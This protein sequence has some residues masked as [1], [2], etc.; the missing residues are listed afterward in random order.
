MVR[1]FLAAVALAAMATTTMPTSAQ[2]AW[3]EAQSDHFVIY[4][5]TSESNLRRFSEQLERYHSAMALVTGVQVSLPSP[6][7]RV[8]VFI[9]GNEDAVRKLY[10]GGSKFVSGFYKARAGGSLA[11]V[12]SVESAQSG[13]DPNFSM[14]VLLHEYA[15]HFLIS[16]SGVAAPRWSSEGAAEFFASAAFGGDGSV[17]LGRAAQHRGYELM[18]ARDVTV[19]DLLDPDHYEKRR[20]KSKE[21]DAFYGRAWLLYHYLTFAEKRK[22]QLTAYHK[23]VAA[24]K[25]SPEAGV[26]AFGDLTVLDKEID[27]YLRKN[28]FTYLKLAPAMLSAPKVTLRPLR[29]GEVAALPVRVRSQVGVDG[30]SAPLVL[31]DARAI[32]ARFPDEAAVEA[33]LAEA[34][35][36]AGNDAEAMAAADVAIKADPGQANA[37]LQKGYAQMRMAERSGDSAGFR[38][39]RET[40][41]ALNAIE[42]DHPLPLLNFY[43]SFVKQGRKPTVNAVEALQRATVVAPFDFGLRMTLAM[44]LVRDGRRDEALL[45]LGPIANNPHGGSLA[46]AARRQIERLK[47]SAGYRGEDSADTAGT[48]GKEGPSR[49]GRPD[50]HP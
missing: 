41:L 17:S 15:H 16:S 44:Q 30:D 42:N 37:Y 47:A 50:I 11:V 21:Y 32:A 25:S 9:V 4:G 18:Q 39:A 8:T 23:A 33:A 20:G 26:A 12:P 14:I 13:G 27:A 3:Q 34:E 19:T 5:N 28:K 29:P 48:T 49:V 40:F 1:R 22:G 45:H 46:E 10:G 2:A 24:G 36:D 31:K 35:F 7:N 6:S 38:K 43:L